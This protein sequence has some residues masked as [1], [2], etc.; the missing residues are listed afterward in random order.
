VVTVCTDYQLII[1]CFPA[2]R[3]FLAVT[4]EMVYEKLSLLPSVTVLFPN[5]KLNL[6]VDFP[7]SLHL[8]QH[9]SLL[10]KCKYYYC[11]L[12]DVKST[13]AIKQH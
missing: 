11:R 6:R 9:S 8:T 1:I 13:G 10:A 12:S 4:M 3:L 2:V 7:M 5:A